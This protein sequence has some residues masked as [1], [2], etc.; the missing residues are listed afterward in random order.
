MKHMLFVACCV[1]ASFLA[2]VQANIFPTTPISST[3]VPAGGVL[4]TQWIESNEAPFAN[5]S[6]T[7]DLF[8]MTGS[9]LQQVQVGVI[10][11]GIPTSTTSVPFT[12]PAN[13][14]PGAYFVK[15]VV[16]GQSVFSTRFIATNAAGEVVSTETDVDLGDFLNSGNATATGN[17]TDV[18]ESTIG[19]NGTETN[20]TTPTDEADDDNGMSEDGI[21]DSSTDDGTEEDGTDNATDKVKQDNNKTSKSNRSVS[22][23]QPLDDAAKSRY[24]M[25]STLV[26]VM[27]ALLLVALA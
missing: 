27:A 10:G 25:A 12:L 16:A 4:N 9:D 1:L 22:I 5:A 21:T 24:A 11:T 8:L 15:F 18:P 2:V 3:R 19:A 23:D 6:E 14:P 20:S 26:A 17:S 13:L 7:Y